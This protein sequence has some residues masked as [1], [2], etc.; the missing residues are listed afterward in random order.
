MHWFSLVLPRSPVVVTSS[1]FR[2]HTQINK[3]THS[4]SVSTQLPT[5][6]PTALSPARV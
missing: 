5:F 4:V 2:Q 1:N 3:R 6:T